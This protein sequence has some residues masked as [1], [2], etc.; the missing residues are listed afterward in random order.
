MKS[1]Q[2]T[3]Y[4]STNLLFIIQFYIYNIGSMY[5]HYLVFIQKRNPCLICAQFM[6]HI[7]AESNQL[8]FLIPNIPKPV[9]WSSGLAESYGTIGCPKSKRTSCLTF[10]YQIQI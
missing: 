10:V 4:T 7:G 5:I 6:V 8:K 2:K 9:L 1:D 3:L